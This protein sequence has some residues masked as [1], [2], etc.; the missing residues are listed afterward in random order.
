MGGFEIKAIPFQIAV[1]L[2]NPHSQTIQSDQV[3]S[4]RLISDQEPGFACDKPG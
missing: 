1:H 3:V 4:A 2:F